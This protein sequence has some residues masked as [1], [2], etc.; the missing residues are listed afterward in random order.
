MVSFSGGQT[1]TNFKV[2]IN[3]P[4]ISSQIAWPRGLASVRDRSDVDASDRCRIDAGPR[5]LVIGWW[6]AAIPENMFFS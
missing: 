4:S 2:K 1:T 5:G 3:I 6:T